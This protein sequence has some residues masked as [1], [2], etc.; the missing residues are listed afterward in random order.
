MLPTMLPTS[1]S[2]VMGILNV[3]PGPLSDGG[4][5]VDT[6]VVA[7]RTYRMMRRGVDIVGIGGESTR[8]G[9]TALSAREEWNHIGV[10]VAA[11]EKTDTV[12]SVDTYHTGTMCRTIDV[13]VEIVSDVTGGAGDPSMFSTVVSSSCLHILQ[14]GRGNAC[15]MNPLVNYGDIRAGAAD[16]PAASIAR[17]ASSGVDAS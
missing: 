17:T 3:T 4:L 16:E 10:V 12:V 13:G 7:E 14:H 2:L 5:Y 15:T 1:C 8:L 9:A 11:L 6:D